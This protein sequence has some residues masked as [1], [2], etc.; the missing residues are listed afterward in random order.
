[1]TSLAIFLVL[2]S[3]FTHALWNLLAKR[4]QGGVTFIWLFGMMEVVFFLPVTLF[5][6]SREQVVI[7]GIEIIMIMGSACLHLVYFISLIR[8]YRVADLSVVY[9]FSRG[10]GPVLST[11]GAIVI[12]SERPTPI[13]VFGTLLVAIGIIGLTGRS[14]QTP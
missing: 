11:I 13:A 5:I 2:S 3:A 9:P 12:L 7:G 1:M 6:V 4:A 8:G 10:I 14:A